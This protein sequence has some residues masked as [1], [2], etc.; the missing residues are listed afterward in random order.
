MHNEEFD[1]AAAHFD[2]ANQ[3]NPIVLYWSA[4][5]NRDLGHLEKA[6]GLAERAANRNTLSANLPFFRS[7][8]VELVMELSS[9]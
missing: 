8:A 5:V 4:V 9:E 2:N 1:A 6:R 3:L 7:A